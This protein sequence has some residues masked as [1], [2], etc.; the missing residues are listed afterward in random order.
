MK[1]PG[2][3]G[4]AREAPGFTSA[5]IGAPLKGLKGVKFWIQG[6]GLK[7]FDIWVQDHRA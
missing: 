4:G 5:A 3:A 6:L 7:E 2:T 1:S